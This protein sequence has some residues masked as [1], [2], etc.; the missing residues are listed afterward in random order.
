[1]AVVEVRATVAIRCPHGFFIFAGDEERGL[2]P[3]VGHNCSANVEHWSDSDAIL[4]RLTS[5]PWE[6]ARGRR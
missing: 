6:T 4:T 3:L 5:K 1:M 2:L